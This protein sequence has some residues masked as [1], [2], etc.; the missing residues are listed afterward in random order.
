M[1]AAN[2]IIRPAGTIRRHEVGGR[3]AMA[4]MCAT[5]SVGLLAGLIA[6]ALSMPFS[7]STAVLG[8]NTSSEIGSP[9]YQVFREGERVDLTTTP[10]AVDRAWLDYRAG[11]RDDPASP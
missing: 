8:G 1:T 10:W 6:P 5:F 3:T 4:L 7:A 11:E 2:G 9:A